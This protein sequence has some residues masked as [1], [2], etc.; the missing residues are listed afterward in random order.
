V[1]GDVG[2]ACRVILPVLRRRCG[3][4]VSH[5]SPLAVF[6]VVFGSSNTY[7]VASIGLGV[8][9]LCSAVGFRMSPSRPTF[10]FAAVVA[11]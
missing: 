4:G 6:V 3:I 10:H 7:S 8:A 5:E 1:W 9:L 2:T 11:G